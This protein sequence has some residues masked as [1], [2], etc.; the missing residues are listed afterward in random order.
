MTE[1]DTFELKLHQAEIQVEK[2][3]TIRKRV[4]ELF[5]PFEISGDNNNNG[6]ICLEIFDD[7]DHKKKYLILVDMRHAVFVRRDS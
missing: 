2:L 5:G 6:G 4:R 3:E 7:G 1:R